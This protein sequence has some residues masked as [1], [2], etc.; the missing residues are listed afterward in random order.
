MQTAQPLNLGPVEPAKAEEK[1]LPMQDE[2]ARIREMLEHTRSDVRRMRM[3]MEQQEDRHDS[4]RR[5]TKTIGIILGGLIFLFAAATWSAYPALRDQK[6]IV[7]D[8]LGLQAVASKLGERL[9]FVQA[10]LGHMS[11]GLPALTAVT[12][13]ME[14]LEETMRANL[15]TASNQAQAT[16]TQL[17]QRIRAEVSQSIQVIQSRLA[18]V[19]SNQKEA[20]EHV[21]QLEEQVAGLKR[22]LAG[23]REEALTSAE[24]I[25]QLTEAQQTNSTQLSGLNQRMTASQASLN[26]LTTRADRKRIDF[27]LPSRH[28]EEV[29]PGI[30]LTFRHTDARNQEVDGTVQLSAEGRQLPIRAQSIQ[31]PVIFYMQDESRPAE[32]VLTQVGKDGVSG[33]LM[34]PAP[35]TTP[36]SQ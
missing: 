2:S 31:K 8:S 19:E 16:A 24:K 32:L 27:K 23:M 34:L 30:Y 20:S 5:L 36:P 6:K 35:A 12:D 28:T 14:K 18:G 9:N 11:A 29:A 21:A 7:A 4:H 3:Q 25:K 22:E 13:R 33:Y 17:G 10:T 1:P 26:T 15:Q